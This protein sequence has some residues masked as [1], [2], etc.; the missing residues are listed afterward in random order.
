MVEWLERQGALGA[1]SGREVAILSAPVGTLERQKVENPAGPRE[2]LVVMLWA[3]EEISKLPSYD[4]PAHALPSLSRRL[5]PVGEPAQDFLKGA[6]LRARKVIDRERESAEIWHWRARAREVV[7]QKRY[8]Q[9]QELEGLA[10]DL[11]EKARAASFKLSP[12]RDGQ[13][14]FREL[15]RFAA[16]YANA[17]GL[18]PEPIGED[19]PALGGRY[20]DLSERDFLKLSQIAAERHRA[21]NWLSGYGEDWDAVPTDT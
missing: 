7:E 12:I 19:F 20:A 4:V 8:P 1:A 10:N 3:L 18:I 9:G 17:R 11:E 16:H 5:P 2:A 15:I 13:S 14:F 6:R 21:L